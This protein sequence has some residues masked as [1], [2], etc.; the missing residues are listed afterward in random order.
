MANFSNVITTSNGFAL[1]AK[2]LE[3][4]CNI[5]FTQMSTSDVSITDN[6]ATNLSSIKQSAV[7]ASVARQNDVNVKVST[8]FDNT[9]LTSGYYVK[10]IG[11]YAMDPDEGEILYSYVT[12]DE[13]DYMPPFNG[14]GTS[15]LLVDMVVVLSGSDKVDLTVTPAAYATVTQIADLQKQVNDIK[16][17]VGYGYENIWGVEVDFKNN[18]IRRIAAAEGL[19]P[20]ADF[21][22]LGPWMRRR[23]NLTYGGM[24]EA[25]HGDEAYTDD[26]VLLVDGD[27]VPSGTA[28]QVMVEQPV[29]YTKVVPLFYEDAASGVGK[30]IVKA[31]YYISDYPLEGF[32]V[33]EVF[34]DVNGNVQ[35]KIY[36]SAYEACATKNITQ[37]TGNYIRDDAA[38]SFDDNSYGL[39]S[40]ANA[41]PISGLTN[42]LTLPNARK[43]TNN[44]NTQ[45]NADKSWCLHNIFALSV[46]QILMLVEYASFDCQNVIGKGVSDL[47]DDGASNLAINTGL[48]ASLGNSSGMADGENGKTSVSYRG[49]ENLWGNIC[50][51]LDGINIEAKSMNNAY[52]GGKNINCVSDT[53]EGYNRFETRLA[54]KTGYVSRFGYD[55]KYDYLFLPAEANGASNKPVNT[56]FY[57]NYTANAF[58]VAMLGGHWSRGTACS[59]WCLD[60]FNVSSIR[61]YNVGCRLLYV[62]QTI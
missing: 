9:K 62:P 31:N 2:A 38:I 49:E 22:N 4:K 19:N 50:T 28:V 34:K 54:H 24:V 40:I 18:K 37:S 48:T 17:Y 13:P 27:S 43:L 1:M 25:Y 42:N 55:K 3:G 32:K 52:V 12:T 33:N 35:D 11:L 8:A 39:A 57:Q 61:R 5:A 47:T 23:C 53:S 59:V 21:D 20:G 29:F 6:T 26:G 7:I 46:T 45:Y 44:I 60:V 15:C 16:G 51:W 14:I 58:C 10:T 41:K 36:L 56:Y 30:Q